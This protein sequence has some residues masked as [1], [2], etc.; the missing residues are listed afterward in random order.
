M[1]ESQITTG[2]VEVEYQGQQF[3]VLRSGTI[4]QERRVS[5]QVLED[6]RYMAAEQYLTARGLSHSEHKYWSAIRT[7]NPKRDV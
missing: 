1:N 7:V 4:L 2:S 3:L 6:V 5:G